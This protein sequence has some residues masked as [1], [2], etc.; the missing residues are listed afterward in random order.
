MKKCRR[1]F[2]IV[3]IALAHGAGVAAAEDARTPLM[4]SDAAR[5]VANLTAAAEQG[6][7]SAQIT[8]AVMY[9]QGRGVPQD[10]SLSFKWLLK[11]AQQGDPEAQYLVGNSYKA[12]EGVLKDDVEALAWRRKAADNGHIPAMVALGYEYT[13]GF[14]VQ[15]NAS[16]AVR[17]FR[18]AA[19]KGDVSAQNF[20]GEAY[21]AGRGVDRD[22]REAQ[23]WFTNAAIQGFATAQFNLGNLY[24][25]N[26]SQIKNNPILGYMWLDVAAEQK[27]LAAAFARDAFAKTLNAADLKKARA[28]AKACIAS[29]YKKCAQ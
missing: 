28:L 21:I 16:E 29:Q 13:Y 22:D 11:A 3:A 8:L 25:H 12:G 5:N 27:D 23:R 14:G 7:L 9:D 18:A 10:K 6:N 1:I 4:Q 19:V 15:R 26:G 2:A 17:L 24:L 20:L